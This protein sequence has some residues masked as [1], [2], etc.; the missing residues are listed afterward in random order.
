[1]T[2]LEERDDGALFDFIFTTARIRLDF[3]QLSI[4]ILGHAHRILDILA[5]RGLSFISI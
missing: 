2:E 5:L 3:F 4:V 1:M